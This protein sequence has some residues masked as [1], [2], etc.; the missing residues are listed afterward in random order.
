MTQ[1]HEE[2]DYSERLARKVIEYRMIANPPSWHTFDPNRNV[3]RG[4]EVILIKELSRLNARVQTLEAK[5]QERS[6]LDE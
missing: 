3:L 1:T 5:L 4:F 2:D 6:V